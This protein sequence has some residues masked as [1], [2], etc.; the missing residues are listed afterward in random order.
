MHIHESILTAFSWVKHNQ[1]YAI[2]LHMYILH[3]MLVSHV[4]QAYFS[5]SA[6]YVFLHALI[7]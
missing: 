3:S 2:Y 7:H 5:S 1:K 6:G 4:A